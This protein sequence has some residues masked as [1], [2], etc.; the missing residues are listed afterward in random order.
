[1]YP[2]Y[3]P[4][5][6]D[7]QLFDELSL[8]ELVPYNSYGGVEDMNSFIVKYR[9]VVRVPQEIK[10]NMT[11]EKWSLDFDR[12]FV[13]RLLSRD[14]LSAEDDSPTSLQHALHSELRQLVLLILKEKYQLCVQK[15]T[16]RKT[17]G[18]K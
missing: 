5:V 7:A 12:K 18:L 4:R 8:K 2:L 17:S 10:A 1:M 14:G 15:L 11:W 16:Q 13:N 9:L 6:I 3:K